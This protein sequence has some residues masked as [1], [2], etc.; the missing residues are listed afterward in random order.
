MMRLIMTAAL[1]AFA[2]AQCDLTPGTD[3]SSDTCTYTAPVTGSDA[4]SAS[5]AVSEGCPNTVADCTFTPDDAATCGT[6]CTYTAPED[7]VVESCTAPDPV[8]T[9]SDTT[10]CTLASSEDF[11]VTP[12]TCAD[13]DSGVATC[14]YVAG[15]YSGDPLDTIDTADSC[16]STTVVPACTLTAGTDCSTGTTCTYVA[17]ADAV[18]ESCVDVVTTCTVV[19][20]SAAVVE[21]CTAPDPVVTESD[22][23][24]C[25]LASSEDFGVTPGTCADADSGVATCAYVAGAYSGDPLDT[26]DTADSCTS[27]TVVPACTLTAGTDCSTG[28][29]CTYEAA[30]PAGANT[31]SD[32]DCTYT[33]A[34][35]AVPAQDAVTAVDEACAVTAVAAATCATFTCTA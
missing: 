25:T 29:T 27:T 19:P 2:S 4:I 34:S 12:G 30:A 1:A 16:T 7:A 17:A 20:G 22:T 18:V 21:S 35:D 28:T 5:D 15:A 9:E 33:A 8:V 26:I 10:A 32:A 23:T 14:A 3:C 6:G 13:A 31:C 24:A 11:G